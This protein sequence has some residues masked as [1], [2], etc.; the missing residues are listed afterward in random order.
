MTVHI[1]EYDINKHLTIVK[2]EKIT[3][4]K[5]SKING[6]ILNCFYKVKTMNCIILLTLMS[7]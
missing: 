4:Y 7:I 5:S 1:K 6:K 3:C 2:N